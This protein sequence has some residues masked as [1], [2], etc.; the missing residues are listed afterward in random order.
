M[1]KFE[2]TKL[3]MKRTFTKNVWYDWYNWLVIHIPEP[4][5]NQW[6]GL[7]TKLIF[8]KN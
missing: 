6:V 7:K 5:K 1:D 2:K 3:T 4:I 8:L